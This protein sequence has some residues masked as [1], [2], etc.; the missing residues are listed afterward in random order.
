MGGQDDI[1]Q[2]KKPRVQFGLIFKDIQTRSG[3]GSFTER[4]DQGGIIHHAAARGIDQDGCGFHAFQFLFSDEMVRSGRIGDVEGHNVS[5]AQQRILVHQTGPAG[6]FNLWSSASRIMIDHFHL[7]ADS[8]TGH[9]LANMTQTEDAQG[10]LMNIQSK[11]LLELPAI[12]LAIPQVG[13][14]FRQPARCGQAS[15]PR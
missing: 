11:K 5:L 12:P 2:F 3:N 14:C 9:H 1:L 7:K 8:P 13:F 6:L 10:S 4:L 15:K